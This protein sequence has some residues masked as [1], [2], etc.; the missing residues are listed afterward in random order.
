LK[1]CI[2][3]KFSGRCNAFAKRVIEIVEVLEASEEAIATTV[4]LAQKMGKTPIVVNDCPGFL[5]NRV[6]MYTRVDT[7][8]VDKVSRTH[9]PAKLRHYIVNLLEVCAVFYKKVKRTKVRD[10]IDVVGIDTGVHGA[11]VMA[12]GFP[13]RMKPDY[14]GSIQLAG[15]LRRL[16]QEGQ[17]HQ[18]KGTIHG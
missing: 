18:S 16:L 4:V 14:K 12:E 11:E 5:V 3:T 7:Y 6:L 13:D 15:S 9:W 17:T 10:L 1:K 8:N 2:P